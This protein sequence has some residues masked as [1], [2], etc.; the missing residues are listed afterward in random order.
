[1]VRS[2]SSISGVRLGAP[3]RDTHRYALVDDHRVLDEDAIRA[4][5]CLRNLYR[6]PLMLPQHGDV[7]LPLLHREGVVDGNALNVI[8][9]AL[10]PDVCWGGERALSG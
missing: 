10:R 9:D 1:M 2:A 8:D 6:L 3:G 5:V 7:L 4:V